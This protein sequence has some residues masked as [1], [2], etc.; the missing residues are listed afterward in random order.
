MKNTDGVIDACNC[1]TLI[2]V[3]YWSLISVNFLIIC[4]D[5]ICIMT[6][7]VHIKTLIADFH[8]FS[9]LLCVYSLLNPQVTQINLNLWVYLL[10]CC[11]GGSSQG[12]HI[13]RWRSLAFPLSVS[14]CEERLQSD[15]VTHSQNWFEPVERGCEQAG[16]PLC[17]TKKYWSN[18]AKHIWTR[19]WALLPQLI[20]DFY[21]D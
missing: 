3:L 6:I 4:L 21:V 10:C 9:V 2:C 20:C 8:T 12:R 18:T 1:S 16:Y 13:C 19:M 11:W 7:K 17:F 14:T 15:V 5:R